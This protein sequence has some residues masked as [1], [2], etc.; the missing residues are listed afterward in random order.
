MVLLIG[1]GPSAWMLNA[2]IID[3]LRG[4]L[5]VVVAA[6]NATGARLSADITGAMDRT[7]IEQLLG[8]G[9]QFNLG[10][11]FIFGLDS[12]QESMRTH[13]YEGLEDG[14]NLF[15]FESSGGG[16][17]PALLREILA[18]KPAGL[19]L[20]GFDGESV[21]VVTY[22]KTKA[23]CEAAARA[24]DFWTGKIREFSFKGDTA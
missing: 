2:R 15:F 22:G 17:G 18:C 23:D 7:P 24:Q 8:S 4:I 14:R 1:N 11:R 3:G 12:L 6:C 21:H 13:H 10:T 16:T 20:I 5:P 19:L 9:R